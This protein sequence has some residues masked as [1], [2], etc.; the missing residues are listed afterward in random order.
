MAIYEEKYAHGSFCP[1]RQSKEIVF[2][3]K[4]PFDIAYQ[5]SYSHT[6]KRPNAYV[7]EFVKSESFVGVAPSLRHYQSVNRLF[8]AN[9]YRFSKFIV[10]RAIHYLSVYSRTWFM[11]FVDT[12]I[13]LIFSHMN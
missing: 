2:S 13:S 6:G 5:K 4:R 1:S 9:Y 12:V 10:I 8:W 7:N 3:R 11:A